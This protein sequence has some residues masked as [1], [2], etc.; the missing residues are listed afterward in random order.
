MGKSNRRAVAFPGGVAFTSRREMAKKPV[1]KD[2]E[3]GGGDG[4][5]GFSLEVA[6]VRVMVRDVL[7]VSLCDS[8]VCLCFV[9]FFFFFFFWFFFWFFF[10]FLHLFFFFSSSFIILIFFL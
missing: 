6:P 7:Y 10:F 1:C 8:K 2:L 5:G 9:L 4:G 3:D